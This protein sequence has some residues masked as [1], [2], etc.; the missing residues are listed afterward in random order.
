MRA[1]QTTAPRLRLVLWRPDIHCG[2]VEVDVKKVRFRQAWHP[3]IVRFMFDE[4]SG[5]FVE[6]TELESVSAL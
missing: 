5:R 4:F 3:G 2:D 6:R 1:G